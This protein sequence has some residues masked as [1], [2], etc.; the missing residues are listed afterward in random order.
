MSK[1]KNKKTVIDSI[2][3]DSIKEAN[4]YC[5]LKLLLKAKQISDLRLQVPFELIPAHRDIVTGRAVRK[6]TYI[7]DFVYQEN[8]KLVVEDT[9]GFKTDSYLIKKKMMSYLATIDPEHY[10]PI[11][12]T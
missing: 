4:R 5:E 8:G 2:E 9:K 11:R 12:E 3:F 7:A 1:Y 6:M 10:Q